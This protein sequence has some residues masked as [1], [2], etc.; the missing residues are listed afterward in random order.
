MP[1]SLLLLFSVCINCLTMWQC[2]SRSGATS[3]NL[4]QCVLLKFGFKCL[5]SPKVRNPN[6]NDN[7]PSIRNDHSCHWPQCCFP[8]KCLDM[9]PD[10]RNG[11]TSFNNLESQSH[12]IE[13]PFLFKPETMAG[14][15]PGF[16]QFAKC[17]VGW[18]RAG[19]GCLFT[20]SQCG[21][22]CGASALLLVS[23]GELARWVRASGIWGNSKRPID[24]APNY[25]H[26]GSKCEDILQWRNE[27]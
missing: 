8:K 13:P 21:R 20:C 19:V 7:C 12:L 18:F 10:Q 4:I 3:L 27:G 23:L 16:W 5:G 1:F 17:L 2:G 9:E 11:K 25:T 6:Q 14:L 22:V 15:F 26:K 24:W